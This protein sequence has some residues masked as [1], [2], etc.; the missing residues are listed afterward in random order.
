MSIKAL[1]TYGKI[2]RTFKGYGNVR[3]KSGENY[4]CRFTLGQFSG[5]NLLISA[6][7]KCLPIEF[8]F[9]HFNDGEVEGFTGTLLDGRSIQLIGPVFLRKMDPAP[10]KLNSRLILHVSQC[11]IGNRDFQSPAVVTFEISNFLFDGTEKEV[12]SADSD[13]ESECTILPLKLG[14]QEIQLQRVSNYKE[15][16]VLLRAQKGVET[17]CVANANISDASDFDK[18]V[19]AIET[20]CLVAS[21]ARGTLINWSAVE[22]KTFGGDPVY[23]IYRDSVIR[24]YASFE[25][26]RR[27]NI[28][29]SKQFFENGYRRYMEL[30][31]D[32]QM[33]RIA[34]A[35]TETRD[36][37][38]IETRTLLIAVLTEYLTGV[39]ARL[40]DRV[41][42]MKED[43]F[44]NGWES[45]KKSIENILS[46]IYPIDNKNFLRAMT[47]NAKG[48][49]RRPFSW[50]INNLAKWLE[51]GFDQQEID[52][53]IATRN[54]LAHSGS[55]PKDGTPVEHY[56]RMQHFLDRIILRLFDYHGK[57]YDF[58]HNEIKEI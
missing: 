12:G 43:I 8:F 42:F 25:L 36:G 53:F 48:L 26:I 31:K 13:K 4:D 54:S 30:N 29:N 50:Q 58:E 18:V 24:K 6:D 15:V 22:V 55:F 7:I 1:R 16:E 52:K 9:K 38:F 57:Y 11:L 10:N 14:D 34:R 39:R 33:S 35:F 37:P 56:R 51:L 49:N 20:F 40:D 19:S 46:E 3:F 27:D 23:S 28:E 32:L 2:I 17:T 44:A 41:Y 5:V 21:V 45:L 47:G